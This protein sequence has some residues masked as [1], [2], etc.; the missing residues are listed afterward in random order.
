MT[1]S[2]QCDKA[3]YCY[4]LFS[5]LGFLSLCSQQKKKQAMCLWWTQK[6]N[7]G[8]NCGKENR[9]QDA[10][11]L[12]KGSRQEV[13]LTLLWGGSAAISSSSAF[14]LWDTS[15][16]TGQDPLFQR[17]IVPLNTHC[18]ASAQDW[19]SNQLVCLILSKI[20]AVFALSN[21]KCKRQ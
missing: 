20:H 12:Q 11:L 14:H 18:Q 16:C 3:G 8:R 6:K 1:A 10:L 21:S 9:F 4:H 2:K 13:Y 17:F 5:P 15:S 7:S 19:H